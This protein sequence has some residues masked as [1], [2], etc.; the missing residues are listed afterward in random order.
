M[1]HE[2]YSVGTKGQLYITGRETCQRLVRSQK[3]RLCVSFRVTPVL[4]GKPEVIGSWSALADDFRTFLLNPNIFEL[5]LSA[6]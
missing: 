4:T 3:T 5:T 2:V 6:V 1:N